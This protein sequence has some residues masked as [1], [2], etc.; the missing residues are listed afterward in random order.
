M[1]KQLARYK[2]FLENSES[3]QALEAWEVMYLHE[4]AIRDCWFLMH[5]EVPPQDDKYGTLT[6]VP[7]RLT[8]KFIGKKF[9]ELLA[10]TGHTTADFQS[11][12]CHKHY[13]RKGGAL[14]PLYGGAF[15]RSRGYILDE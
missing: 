10:M 14:P 6:S 5:D 4:K 9:H 12:T 1:Q 2:E 3:M 13:M 8:R 11:C 15:N 7:N